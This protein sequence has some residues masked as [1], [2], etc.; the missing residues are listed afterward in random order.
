MAIPVLL[1][2]VLIRITV[3]VLHA[4][5]PHSS[6]VRVLERTVSWVVWVGLVMWL[7]GLLPEFERCQRADAR[8][9]RPHGLPCHTR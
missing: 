9:P 1:S 8:D 5:F 4:A 6:A 7:T 3:R 2:L